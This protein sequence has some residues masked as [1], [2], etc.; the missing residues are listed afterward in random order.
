MPLP[1]PPS[2]FAQV[3]ANPH[4]FDVAITTYEM[5]HSQHFG[6][7][8]K[9]TINWRYLVR[10]APALAGQPGIG[11][12][13]TAPALHATTTEAVTQLLILPPATA[14]LH[15]V[16]DEGHKIKTDTTLVSQS[17]RLIL[18]QHTLLLTGARAGGLGTTVCAPAT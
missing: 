1:P 8:L 14:L 6:H 2:L 3:L 17:V 4:T 15:Q 7:A 16:L 13:Y 11:T 9:T 18:R 5:L 10:R 12:T